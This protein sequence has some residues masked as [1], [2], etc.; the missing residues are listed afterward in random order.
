[1][2]TYE[3]WKL[4]S[5][6]YKPTVKLTDVMLKRVYVGERGKRVALRKLE[7]LKLVSVERRANRNPSVTVFFFE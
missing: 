1:V 4:V 7:G 5:R 6:G 2:L 3:A